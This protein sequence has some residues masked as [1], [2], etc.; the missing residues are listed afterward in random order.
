MRKIHGCVWVLATLD[1][2]YYLQ[3]PTREAGFLKELLAP[4]RSV[5]VSDFHTGY[6]SAACAQQDFARS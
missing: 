3:R 4:F 2:V 5:L 6:D 1:K